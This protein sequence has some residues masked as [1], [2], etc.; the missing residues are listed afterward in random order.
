MSESKK[1]KTTVSRKTF[2]TWDF[3]KDF[4][5]VIVFF[6]EEADSLGKQP[7]KMKNMCYTFVCFSS[8]MTDE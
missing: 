4:I 1:R 7:T 5:I 6:L 8:F 2:M 3:H